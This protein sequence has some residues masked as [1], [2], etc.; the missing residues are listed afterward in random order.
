[1]PGGVGGGGPG[2]AASSPS[3]LP[4]PHLRAAGTEFISTGDSHFS[5]KRPVAVK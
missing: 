3:P 5:Q 1:M 2:D 4:L